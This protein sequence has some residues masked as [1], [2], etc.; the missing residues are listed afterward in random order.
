ME[1]MD[2]MYPTPTREA[3]AAA[4]VREYIE[5]TSQPL[6]DGSAGDSTN[7]DS[8]AFHTIQVNG[9]NTTQNSLIQSGSVYQQ[10]VNELQYRQEL[11]VS[12]NRETVSARVIPSGQGLLSQVEQHNTY[13]V[14]N[15]LEQQIAS[16][17]AVS[18]ATTTSTGIRWISNQVSGTADGWKYVITTDP[19]DK[20]EPSY[21]FFE[22]LTLTKD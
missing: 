19:Y 8:T 3:W 7:I 1:R 6:L 21:N 20:E 10:A 16:L 18:T 11:E 15:N 14:N 4:T 22:H 17:D 2:E 5:N 9:V 13:T 12:R